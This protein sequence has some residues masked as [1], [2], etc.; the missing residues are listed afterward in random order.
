MEVKL[1]AW[2][3]RL[4]YLNQ[5]ITPAENIT[6]EDVLLRQP[7]GGEILTERG[8]D[9]Q[10]RLFREFGYPVLIMLARIVAQRAFGPA[11]DFLLGLL[12]ARK[13]ELG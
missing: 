6:N 3:A 10:V 8:G 13:P 2:R 9:E 1:E 12:V 5:G 4:R 11:V 7:F